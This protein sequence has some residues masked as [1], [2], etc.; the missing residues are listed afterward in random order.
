MELILDKSFLDAASQEDIAGA[1]KNHFIIMP[2]V[3]FYELITT[4]ET[5]RERCFK[6]L[7][8]SVNPLALLPGISPLLQHEI[9]TKTP[10]IPLSQHCMPEK[11]QFNVRLG[12][13]TFE[14][15]GG[16]LE[17]RENQIQKTADDTRNFVDRCL[18]V[19]HFFPEVNGIPYKDFPKAIETARKKVASDR[20][21]V[22]EVYAFFLEDED[23]PS[24]MPTPA[25]IDVQWA[26]FRWVQCQLLAALRLFLRYQGAMPPNRSESFW[27]NAEH[28]MLDT[29]Y[30]IFGTLTG[31][32]A[33][34]D[35]EVIEDFRLVCPDGVLV[36]PNSFRVAN[37]ALH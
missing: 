28:T 7:P 3:L 16:A 10:C 36:T 18:V 37:K 32:L 4:R 30:V 2:D 24:G 14:F 9:Q 11:F 33:S 8:Q 31:A 15:V 20:D 17:E 25:Q 26:T 35:R 19:H 12:A 27:I 21:F 22:R 5:S 6:K 13:G 23:S 1:W 29:Y 34:A